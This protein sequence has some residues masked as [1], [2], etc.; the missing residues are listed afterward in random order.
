MKKNKIISMFNCMIGA[1]VTVLVFMV[2]SF[3][4][5]LFSSGKDGI[6]KCFFDTL[7]FKS[8]TNT[9]KSVSMSLGFTGE[10]FPI[11]LAVIT[12]YLFYFCT[13]IFTKKLLGYRQQLIEGM[14]KNN[15]EK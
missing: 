14:N 2:F 5:M 7:Y 4:V 8:V 12:V 15:E 1:I 6:R 11:I 10:F 13:Y 3:M 9:D